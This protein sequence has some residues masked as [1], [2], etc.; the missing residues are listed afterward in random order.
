MNIKQ[1]M[2]DSAINAFGAEL[3]IESFLKSKLANIIYKRNDPLNFF[4]PINRSDTPEF[5]GAQVTIIPIKDKKTQDSIKTKNSDA[6]FK[7]QFASDMLKSEVLGDKLII[8]ISRDYL[9]NS[10][11]CGITC[12]GQK[13]V[14][15]KNKCLHY[16]AKA[17]VCSDED[18][19]FN[20]AIDTIAKD[21]LEDGESWLDINNN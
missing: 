11:E 6:Y 1:L 8:T 16:Y 7:H 14:T 20:K 9:I 19:A 15:D 3:F 10:A 17:F 5:I 4:F 12:G 13:S 2:L 21:A 18:S